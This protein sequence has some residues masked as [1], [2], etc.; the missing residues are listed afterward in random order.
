M[1]KVLNL[2]F[3]ILLIVS[4]TDC[5]KPAEEVTASLTINPTKKEIDANSGSFQIAVASTI[6]WTVSS[7]KN[8]ITVSPM[9]GTGNATVKVDYLEN[10]SAQ[11]RTASIVFKGMGV[12]DKVVSASQSGIQPILTISPANLSVMAEAGNTVVEITSNLSWIVSSNQTWCTPAQ[13][14]GIGNASLTLNFQANIIQSQRTAIITFAANG[15]TNQTVQITQAEFIPALAVSPQNQIVNS[16]QGSV[17]YTI[18][19]NIG[20]TAICAES[21][22]TI[23]NPNGSNSSTLVVNYSQNT[24]PETRVATIVVSGNGVSNQSVVLTQTNLI[25]TLEVTPPN[26]DVSSAVGNTTFNITSNSTWTAESDQTWCTIPTTTGTGD[27]VLNINYE[28][29]TVNSQR[30]ATITISCNGLSP[31]TVTLNQHGVI[32]TDG[33]V[34]WYPFNG[35]ANDESGNGNNGIVSGAI[36]TQDRSGNSNRAYNFNGISD[37]INC[38]TNESFGLTSNSVLSISAWVKPFNS[39]GYCVFS[40][41][42]HMAPANSKYFLK[43]SPNNIVVS[44]DGTNLIDYQTTSDDWTF[45]VIIYDNINNNTKIYKNGVFKTSG[46][47]N[48]NSNL[49]SAAFCIGDFVLGGYAFCGNID[50]IRVYSRELTALEIQQLYNE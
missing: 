8:W 9:T 38:G 44:G 19:S 17:N 18:T 36:L 34:A 1:K 16:P 12:E 22:C 46:A 27:G 37:K 42:Q 39:G 4:I 10:T 15:V 23:A 11:G 25:P 31:K 35:N 7:D 3:G 24:T 47:L 43:V 14:S 48:Y 50:D 13:S 41:Y 29:N 6:Q 21:W 30:L 45:F 32:P 28:A 2:V 49:S 40:K 20:W 5:K 26:Q 33:L